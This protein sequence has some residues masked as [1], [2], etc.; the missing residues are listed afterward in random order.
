MTKCDQNKRPHFIEPTRLFRLLTD[1]ASMARVIE[2]NVYCVLVNALG[3]LLNI[4]QHFMEVLVL[5][6][7]IVDSKSKGIQ[8][9]LHGVGII[10]SIF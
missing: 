9:F 3:E 6:E 8:L 1:A 5:I 2:H 4:R 7:S 10:F